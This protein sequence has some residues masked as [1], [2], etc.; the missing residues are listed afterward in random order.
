MFQFDDFQTKK[1]NPDNY[2]YSVFSPEVWP[3]SIISI[4]MHTF[5]KSSNLSDPDSAFIVLNLFIGS[6]L[7]QRV[8]QKLHQQHQQYLYEKWWTLTH[9]KVMFASYRIPR[10]TRFAC[11]SVQTSRVV[12][13]RCAMRTF[14]AC[15]L[16]ASRIALPA[17]RSPVER[18]SFLVVSLGLFPPSW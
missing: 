5:N 4:R 13:W 12:R 6:N 11:M 15:G 17:F 16:T 3:W 7:G 10:T 1:K 2:K 18:K 8:N 9:F 14:P